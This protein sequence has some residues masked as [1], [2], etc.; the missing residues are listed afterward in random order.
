MR[1]SGYE[2]DHK[3]INVDK[4]VDASIN[5]NST[6]ASAIEL[7]ERMPGISNQLN[8]TAPMSFNNE[9]T[10]IKD[11]LSCIKAEMKSLESKFLDKTSLAND[12]NNLKERCLENK[13]DI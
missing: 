3:S 4:N 5:S 13:V 10:I 12:L 11:K 2:F 7:T 9:Q 8:L 6:E 1:R